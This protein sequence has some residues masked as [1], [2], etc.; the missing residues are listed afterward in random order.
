M[1]NGIFGS[2]L[3]FIGFV[4]THGL[5]FTFTHHDTPRWRM[6]KAF[7]API[8]EP[9]CYLRERRTFWIEKQNVVSCFI[10]SPGRFSCA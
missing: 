3:A 1:G 10:M 8:E 2:A 6:R 7:H 4:G 5:L 9:T